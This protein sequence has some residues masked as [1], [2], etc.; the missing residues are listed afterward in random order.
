MTKTLWVALDQFSVPPYFDFQ[1]HPRFGNIFIWIQAHPWFGN[2]FICIS[3]IPLVWKCN[4]GIK[5]FS[6]INKGQHLYWQLKM[7]ESVECNEIFTKFTQQQ[8]L[9]YKISKRSANLTKHPHLKLVIIPPV[10]PLIIIFCKNPVFRKCEVN[11]VSMPVMIIFIHS[12]YAYHCLLN[13]IK[14]KLNH[15]FY[16][17]SNQTQTFSAPG[18]YKHLT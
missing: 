9:K 5:Q 8:G 4:L 13:I 7:V 17:S 11:L 18:E 14:N 3:N 12:D 1:A 10:S 2:I 16:L 6:F 15:K